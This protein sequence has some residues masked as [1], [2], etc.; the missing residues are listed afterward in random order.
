MKIK[1]YDLL[2]ELTNFFLWGGNMSLPF[3]LSVTFF[4]PTHSLTLHLASLQSVI[5]PLK[6]GKYVST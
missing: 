3:L 4:A 5:S 1:G 2:T 6:F